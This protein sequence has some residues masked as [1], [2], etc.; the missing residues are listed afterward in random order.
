MKNSANYRVI[1]GDTDQMGVVYYAN[2]LRWFELG[3]T[4]FLRQLATPYTSIEER[5]FYFPVTEATCRYRTPA[6]FD[7]LIVIETTLASLGRA[8]FTVSYRLYRQRDSAVVATGETRHA[9]VNREGQVTR[10]PA[11][12][13]KILKS[14]LNPSTKTSKSSPD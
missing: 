11:D 7:D 5:G 8:S 4:E 6:R 1:Y 3:R 13:E 10:I 14:A 12:L 2:Y 9:C